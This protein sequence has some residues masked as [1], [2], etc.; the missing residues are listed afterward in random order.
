M[1]IYQRTIDIALRHIRI[2]R[3]LFVIHHDDDVGV[4]LGLG[5]FEYAIIILERMRDYNK[6]EGDADG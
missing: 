1:D 4:E 6:K 5:Q 3:D 2:A